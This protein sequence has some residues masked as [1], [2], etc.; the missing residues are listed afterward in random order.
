VVPSLQYE[1]QSSIGSGRMQLVHIQKGNQPLADELDSFSAPMQRLILVPW[2]TRSYRLV[3]FQH[4]HMTR[5]LCG[6]VL[7]NSQTNN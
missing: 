1:I 5:N 3:V 6:V 2:V 7:C 4:L